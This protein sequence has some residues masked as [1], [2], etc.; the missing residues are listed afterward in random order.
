MCE[1]RPQIWPHP[2]LVAEYVSEFPVLQVHVAVTTFHLQS[3]QAGQLSRCHRAFR[4][5][6]LLLEQTQL[7]IADLVTD[8]G[9]AGNV[10]VRIRR[11]RN[12][13]NCGP[14]DPPSVLSV[15][16][17]LRDS[18]RQAT[19]RRVTD[20]PKHHLRPVL[21]YIAHSSASAAYAGVASPVAIRHQSYMIP[22]VKAK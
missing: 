6:I 18:R 22:F 10:A 5:R 8:C 17:S 20:Q 7:Q 15:A 3:H 11:I 9:Q 14:C 12:P 21:R 2:E 16:P 13:V 19:D 4:R 1:V